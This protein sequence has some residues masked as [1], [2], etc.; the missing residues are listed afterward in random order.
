M[1]TL[2]PGQTNVLA[3]ENERMRA[4]QEQ[5]IEELQAPTTSSFNRKP[6]TAF[7]A[8]VLDLR[9]QLQEAKSKIAVQDAMLRADADHAADAKEIPVVER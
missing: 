1:L 5:K 9:Q 2:L 4:Q 6:V 8:A 7:Q 3:A